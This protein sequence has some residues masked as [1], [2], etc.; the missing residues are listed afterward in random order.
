VIQTRLTWVV[1]AG[2]AALLVAGVVDALRSSGSPASSS[3]ASPAPQQPVADQISLP[4]QEED[5][6]P[7]PCTA[8]QLGLKIENL[9]GVAALALVHVWAGPC[10][11]PRL[12]IEV[13]VLDRAGEPVEGTIGIQPAFA[14][15]TLSPDGELSAPFSLVYLCG[16]PKPVRVAAEAGPYAAT[17]RLPRRY[18][19]CLEDL[20][21]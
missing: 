11:T 21:P 16:E 2:V 4:T 17:G 6:A 10:R 1:V 12:P 9:G 18:A 20:G 14:P 7:P 13:A 15:T 5:T 3:K 19:A 8:Q